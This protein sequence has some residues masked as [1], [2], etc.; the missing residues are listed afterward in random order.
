MRQNIAQPGMPGQDGRFYIEND[1]FNQ[2]I[3][4]NV[5]RGPG[6]YIDSSYSFGAF[7]SRQEGA[8]RL[9]EGSGC[10][11]TSAFVTGEAAKITIGEFTILNATTLVCYSQVTIGSHCMLAWGSVVTDTWLVPSPDSILLRRA[12]LEKAAADPARVLPAFAQPAPVVLEDHCWIGFGAIV[13]PGVKVGR[14]AVVGSK[15]IVSEDVPPYAVVV[16]DPARIVRYLDPD[17][18]EEAKAQAFAQYLA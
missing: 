6:V 14:G 2:G 8:L 3:P 9:G 12:I 11:D 10:Y 15:T 18:T 16:G 13:L 7:H 5:V 17:D 1:W 4:A